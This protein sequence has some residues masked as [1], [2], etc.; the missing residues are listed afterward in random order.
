METTSSEEMGQKIM[1][2]KVAELKVILTRRGLS[3]VG[4]KK[5]LMERLYKAFEEEGLDPETVRIQMSTIEEDTKETHQIEEIG[6]GMRG[7]VNIIEQ[8]IIPPQT[9]TEET[10]S[11]MMQA[12]MNMMQD[13][14][15]KIEGIHKNMGNIQ[16][17][18]GNMQQN[19]KEDIGNIQQDI[20]RNILQV[21]QNINRN[22]IKIMKLINIM[23]EKI[24]K[25]KKEIMTRIESNQKKLYEKCKHNTV[26]HRRKNRR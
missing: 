16:Q 20:E 12:I 26:E 10:Q 4:N 25:D 8:S 11:G 23:D 14:G 6:D 1:E 21:N 22:E 9:Y 19:I 18:M 7:R 3:I 5:E 17:D 2:L 15:S 24:E 13:F